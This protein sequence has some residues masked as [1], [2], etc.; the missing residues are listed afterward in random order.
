MTLTIHLVGAGLLLVGLQWYD[1]VL[2][3]RRWQESRPSHRHNP[4]IPIPIDPLIR[5][6][7]TTQGPR[8]EERLVAFLT[9]SKS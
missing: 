3:L 1:A 4:F 9:R 2:K 8:L 6:R 5:G 7:E